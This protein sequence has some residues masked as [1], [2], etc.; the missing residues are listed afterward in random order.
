MSKLAK[1]FV[2]NPNNHLKSKEIQFYK[3][4]TNTFQRNVKRV[5]TV[6]LLCWSLTTAA[7]D[8]IEITQRDYNNKEVSMA[9]G[10]RA[11]GKIYVVVAT[12]ASIMAGILVYVI[13]IDRNVKKLEEEFESNPK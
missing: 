4:Y 9:D 3:M 13:K 5:L 2:D 12:L 7:Q 1:Q 6:I 8:K 11:D 10:M